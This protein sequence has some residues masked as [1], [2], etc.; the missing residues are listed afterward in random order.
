MRESVLSNLSL[1]SWTLQIWKDHRR[2]VRHAGHMAAIAYCLE[3][4]R[5]WWK[6]WD[7]AREFDENPA[8]TTRLAHIHHDAA[9]KAQLDRG[10]LPEIKTLYDTLREKC[11]SEFDAI[12]T[13]ASAF[14]EENEH[15]H[16]RGGAFDRE[17]F[18]E[19]ARQAVRELQSQNL[20][21]S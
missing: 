3:H 18:I 2:G 11:Y 16:K 12:H 19:R 7:T 4:H 6:D 21:R 17:R 5:E 14:A 9:I 15:V 8:M 20:V 10:D 1:L 13:L